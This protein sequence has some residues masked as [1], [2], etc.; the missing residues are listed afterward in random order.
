MNATPIVI[1]E[2][3]GLPVVSTNNGTPMQVASNGFGIPVTLVE[4]FGTPVTI[5]GLNA[6]SDGFDEGFE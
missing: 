3:G 6:F 5:S 2:S 4:N 1:V